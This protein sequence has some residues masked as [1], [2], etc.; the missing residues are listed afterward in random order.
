LKPEAGNFTSKIYSRLCKNFLN[1]AKIFGNFP[2]LAISIKIDAL[3][4]GRRKTL[5]H[6]LY[7]I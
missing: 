4:G 6:K 7:S 5:Q 2:A 3:F 1:I